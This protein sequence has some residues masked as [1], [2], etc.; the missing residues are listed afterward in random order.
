MSMNTEV[1]FPMEGGCSCRAVRHR[2]ALWSNYAGAGEAIRFVRVGTL[3]APGRVPPDVHI[4]TSTK[5]PW[6]VLPPEAPAYPEYDKSSEMWP[7]ESLSR[8]S[9]AIAAAEAGGR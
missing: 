6:V 7:A 4:F 3:D 5:Q 9:A 8:R 2:I 1:A